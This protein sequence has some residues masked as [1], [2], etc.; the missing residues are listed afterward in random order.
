MIDY[1]KADI[2]DHKIEP[3]IPDNIIDNV[4]EEVN[5]VIENMDEEVNDV[6]V[7]WKYYY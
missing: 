6:D 4:D 7:M 5:D 3:D 1:G 2:E